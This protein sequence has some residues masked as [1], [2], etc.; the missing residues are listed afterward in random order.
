MQLNTLYCCSEDFVEIVLL[1]D[2]LRKN[3]HHTNLHD[4]LQYVL[5]ML[6]YLRLQA[7]SE[8]QKFCIAGKQML[9]HNTMG[10]WC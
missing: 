2:W 7:G 1:D 6:S 8:Y 4:K 5:K 10:M 3:N 9:K